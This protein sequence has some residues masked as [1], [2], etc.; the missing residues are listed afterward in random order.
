[1]KIVIVGAGFTGVQLAK[2]LI[3]KKNIVSII[4]SDE[5]NVRHVSNQLD[6]TVMLAEGNDLHTLEEAG[7][8]KADALICVTDNDEINMITCSL[9]DAVYPDVL[10]IAR[11]R[12]YAY[13]V[14]TAEA[15]KTHADSFSGKH[16]PLYGIDYM[17][18]PDVEAADAI[19]QAVQSGAI[20]DVQAFE[21]SEYELTRMTV[22]EGS[23][24]AGKQLQHVHSLTDAHF[25]IAYVENEG[26]TSLPSGNTK[27]AVGDSIGVLVSKERM[28]ELLQLCGSTQKELKSIALV[29]AGRI[30]T[31]IAEKLVQ[32]KEKKS[33]IN[34]FTKKKMQK[35][36]KFVI[37]DSNEERAN[38]AS[39]RFP[40]AQVFCADATDEHFLSEEGIKDFDLAICATHNH[41]MNMVLAAFLESLGV[42]KSVS[43][44]S[45]SAFSTI[46]RKLGVDVPIPIRD[47]VV[48]SIMSHLRGKS[49]KEIHTVTTGDLEIIE[50]VLP[51]DSK[52]INKTLREI[53]KPGSF[54]IML[55][56]KYN[57]SEFE[58]PVGD[59]ILNAGDDVILITHVEENSNIVSFF[60][61]NVS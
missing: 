40:N 52:A 7:I 32:P 24:L 3:S 28:N 57:A 58:I 44:V 14:N 61:G 27:L 48:D 19:V 8:A 35:L 6:C 21:N 12:N 55:V 15:K 30:G 20:N 2:N 22:N 45:S 50:C 13:Y 54:L 10:K 37:I 31:I 43:L 46:A 29:G 33:F 39:E 4:D 11:V 42:G 41:E 51:G 59:T 17:I 16:R 1:M 38:L 47:A 9:V 36:Q 34:F 23:A 25:L 60:G 5:N 26:K 18:H 53:A 49:V 56:K